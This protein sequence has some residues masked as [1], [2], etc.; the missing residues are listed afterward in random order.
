VKKF[1]TRVVATFRE[2]LLSG[3]SW[4]VVASVA[5]QGSVLLASIIVARM[6][7]LVAFG[8][9]ALL[10]STVMTVAAVAQ[11]GSGLAATKLVGEFLAFGPERVGR[12]LKALRIFA[13]A[14]GAIAAVLI[15][16]LS[17]VLALDLFARPELIQS[18]R[19]VALA[20]FFLVFASHQIGALQGFGAFREMSR[21]SVLTGICHIVLTSLGA[22][23]GEVTGALLGFVAA[24][25]LRAVFFAYALRAVRRANGV[26]DLVVVAYDDFR[27]VWHF[28]VPAGLAGIVTMPCLWLVTV[29]V[30][31]LQD[32][33]ALV[34]MLSVAHQLRLAVLQLP[35]LLNAVSFSVLSRLKG[36][37]EEGG[38]R[39]IFWLNVGIN[40]VFSTLAVAVLIG[41]SDLLLALYG[42]EF[43]DGR[44]LLVVVLFSVIPESIAMSIYQRIQSAGRMWQSLFFIAIPRDVGYLAVSAMVV[45][46]YGVVAAAAAYLAAQALGLACTA[47]L[48][49][50]LSRSEFP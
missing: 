2:H 44:W 9:Y 14:T 20:T 46:Q 31:R 21:A 32:G 6:L 30:S 33:L 16:A 50:S 10:V 3:L 34:A 7:G 26:Q 43:G 17:E 36:R 24:S 40:A 27:P 49:Y 4:N 8:S 47:V 37:D 19:L 29:L 11:G 22:Y 15:L 45:P 25:A 28:A 13:F 23:F 42:R 39:S 1:L 48:A 38:F 12:L 18:L 5:M 41:L 35:S